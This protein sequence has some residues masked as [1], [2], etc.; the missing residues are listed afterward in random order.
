MLRV[1]FTLFAVILKDE[2]VNIGRPKTVVPN[3][4]Q[5]LYLLVNI[6]IYLLFA[7]CMTAG[8]V[9]FS[10]VTLVVTNIV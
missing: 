8:L 3:C 1:V 6:F 9:M 2:Q 5:S 4:S 7:E 10:F